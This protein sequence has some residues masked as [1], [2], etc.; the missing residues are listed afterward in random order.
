MP[1]NYQA[2]L[3]LK[4]I[5]KFLVSKQY[6]VEK[7]LACIAIATWNNIQKQMKGAILNTFLLVRLIS[8]FIEFYLNMYKTS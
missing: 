7:M 3:P 4:E 2:S 5:F 8:L 6:H 1:H